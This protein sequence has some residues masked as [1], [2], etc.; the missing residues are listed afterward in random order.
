MRTLLQ[1]PLPLVRV[2]ALALACVTGVSAPAS[3]QDPRGAVA[4]RVSDSSGGALPGTTVTVTNEATGTSNTAVADAQGSSYAPGF[5]TGRNWSSGSGSFANSVSSV[6]SGMSAAMVAA[7][8]S[9]SSGS[10]FSGGGGGGG[11]SGG[12]GGGGGGGGW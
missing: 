6:A 12:G 2:A 8:P 4:G 11:G 7:Q 3:A 5:Y 1:S 9:S 10:G